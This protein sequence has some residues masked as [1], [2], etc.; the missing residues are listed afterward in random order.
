EREKNEKAEKLAA[1][2]QAKRAELAAAPAEG[3]AP[4]DAKKALIAAA[5][6][7]AQ[8]KKAEVAP[9]NID[10]LP[11]DTQREIEEIEARR[12]KIREM[13][14]QPLESEEKKP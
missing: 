9:K 1:K 8:A 2:A 7:R 12:A 4:S 3:A 6:A 11:P 5:L 14:R 13:A 10:H